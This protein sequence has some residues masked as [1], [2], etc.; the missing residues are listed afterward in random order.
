MAQLQNQYEE[1]VSQEG[2]SDAQNPNTGSH[3][4]VDQFAGQQPVSQEFVGVTADPHA[5]H[6]QFS[7]QNYQEQPQTY[8]EQPQAQFAPSPPMAPQGS[9]E[10]AGPTAEV[11]QQQ[12]GGEEQSFAGHAPIQQEIPSGG[13]IKKMMFGGAFVAALAVGGGAAYTYQYIDLF[14]PQSAS[15]P[16]PTIK[17]GSSPIKFLKKKLAGAGE[18]INKAMHNSLSGND[19][20][21]NATNGLDD[22]DKIVDSARIAG[23]KAAASSQGMISN[24]GA[25]KSSG[26]STGINAPRRVKNTDCKAR[27]HHL[28]TRGQ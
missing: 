20:D 7:A 9:Y 14:G 8:Q 22:L 16:A 27:W 24:I 1:E 25:K 19:T 5:Q 21:K 26:G 23:D 17:A 10:Y 6:E 4:A 28:A 18:S 13:G 3:Q 15:G 12:F 11:S 2:W